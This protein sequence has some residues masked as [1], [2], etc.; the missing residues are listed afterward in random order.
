MNRTDR[1]YAITEELRA[2]APSPRSASWLARRFEVSARTIERDIGALQQA[3]TPIWAEPGRTGGYAIDRDHTLPPVNFGAEEAMA[4]AVALSLAEADSPF[5]IA[6]ASALRKLLTAMRDDDAAEAG[7]LVSRVHLVGADERSATLPPA[8]TD[9]VSRRRVLR[10]HYTDK[11]GSATTR[12]VEPLGYVR[13]TTAW[14]L[15]AWCRLRDG[16]R[17][18][19]FD[20]VTKVTALAE[21]APARSVLPADIQVPDGDLRTLTLL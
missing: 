12:E 7:D 9:A 19:R 20:R 5:R 6:G 10:L 4:V 3:G 14:Y 18:F 8:L 11:E 17:A 13:S 15:L 16:L 1:L 21:A 2:S